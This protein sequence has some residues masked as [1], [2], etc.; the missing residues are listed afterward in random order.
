MALD[1]GF[2]NALKSLDVAPGPSGT[3]TIEGGIAKFPITGGHVTVYKPGEVNPYVQGK[4]MHD[5]SGLTLTKG[6]TKVTLENF[7]IDPGQPATL[8]GKVLANG[9]VAAAS[10]TLFDLDGS[11]LKPITTDASAGTA[12][13][14]G[15]TVK[16]S[17]AAASTLNG[18]F[19]TDAL[20]GG[21]TVGIATIVVKLPGQTSQTP[22]GGVSTGGG[23]TS[24]IEDTGL[25]AAGAVALL[26]AGV[27][28]GYA[29]RRRSAIE[30]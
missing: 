27:A 21:T 7:V 18:A 20:K 30:R 25:L 4:I 11:T 8:T 10:A 22:S 29:A 6:D 9:N 12:T 13:L 16:L 28:A 3:A 26:G 15:T 24:G 14:T 17:D 1:S 2:V 5:G 19:K 23:S